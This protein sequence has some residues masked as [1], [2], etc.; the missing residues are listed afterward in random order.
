MLQTCERN[1]APSVL[2]E[3]VG[4][5]ER[6]GAS[7][8]GA[9]RQSDA[10]QFQRSAIAIMAMAATALLGFAEFDSRAGGRRPPETGSRLPG[11]MQ[12]AAAGAAM[13]RCVAGHMH[14]RSTISLDADVRGDVSSARLPLMLVTA[15][16]N[17]LIWLAEPATP[18]AT[19]S[20]VLSETPEGMK[21]VVASTGAVQQALATVGGSAEWAPVAGALH[22]RLPRRMAARFL[23]EVDHISAAVM[24]CANA[25]KHSNAAAVTAAQDG[26]AA[27]MKVCGLCLLSS[28]LMRIHLL[29]RTYVGAALP[30]LNRVIGAVIIAKKVTMI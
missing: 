4:L 2:Y 12:L 8:L 19:A 29:Q 26:M 18:V 10:W 9:L 20:K 11:S 15:L 30:P 22:R 6:D 3:T 16:R 21:A 23:T 13:M 14:P 25:G 24:A 7:A 5:L 27:L 17:V 1:Y 28:S